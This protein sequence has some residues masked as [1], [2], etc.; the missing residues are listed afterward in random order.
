MAAST[1]RVVLRRLTS[2]GTIVL[3]G[4]LA[5]ALISPSAIIPTRPFWRWGLGLIALI[6]L[7][8]VLELILEPMWRDVGEIVETR[9]PRWL[10]AVA[11]TLGLLLS[12]LAL[13]VAFGLLSLVPA[14]AA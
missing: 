14:S 13:A 11:I 3:G 6:V 5:V 12:A 10:K 8:G 7:M 2:V 9:E 1:A 4:A